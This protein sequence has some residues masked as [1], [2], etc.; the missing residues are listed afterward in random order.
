[1]FPSRDLPAIVN[2]NNTA[3]NEPNTVKQSEKKRKS[4]TS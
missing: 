4:L 1:M 2:E 3:P